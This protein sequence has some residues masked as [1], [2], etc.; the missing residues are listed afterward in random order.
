MSPRIIRR[1]GRVA[2]VGMFPPWTTDS[3]AIEDE[4]C[5]LLAQRR[6]E[7]RA[8]KKGAST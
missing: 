3:A 4:A 8:V 5:A 7:Q 6:R 1:T 2:L